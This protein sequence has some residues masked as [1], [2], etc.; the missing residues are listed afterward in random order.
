MPKGIE[1]TD[2]ETRLVTINSTHR[3]SVADTTTDFSVDLIDAVPELRDRVL[4]VSVET[5]GYL[6][7]INNVRH[8][9]VHLYFSLTNT[10]NGTTQYKATVPEGQYTY[11]DYAAALQTAV[12]D[13]I[14]DP[15]YGPPFSVLP[16]EESNGQPARLVLMY[17]LAEPGAYMTIPYDRQTAP[18]IIGMNEDIRLD[19]DIGPLDFRPNLSGPMALLLHTRSLAGS[20]SSVNGDGTPSEA[21]LTVPVRV[22]YGRADNIHMAGDNRPLVVYSA[23]AHRN[24]ANIDVALKHLDG[25]PV[26]LGT[27]EMYVTFRVWLS[28]R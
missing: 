11:I 1:E 2:M 6:N 4:G 22:P 27:G 7:V 25:S 3:S 19:N 17:L 14:N 9:F 20:R 16:L 13:A 24:L 15:I 21:L 18:F 28:H 10:T 8:P 26:D 23:G 12:R 5:V